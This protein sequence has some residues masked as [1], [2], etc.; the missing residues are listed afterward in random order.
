MF[1][2][3]EIRQWMSF[4]LFTECITT[5][6]FTPF[7]CWHHHTNNL[8]T[9]I[10]ERKYETCPTKLPGL[11]Y[12]NKSDTRIQ[13]ISTNRQFLSRSSIGRSTEIL[14]ERKFLFLTQNDGFILYKGRITHL[15]RFRLASNLQNG[16]KIICAIWSKIEY[17][18]DIQT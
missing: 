11:Q 7:T 16:Y 18:K 15:R 2:R 3:C 9:E 12:Y 13:F 6:L 4:Q 17:S 8:N 14:L 10:T 1:I 5:A